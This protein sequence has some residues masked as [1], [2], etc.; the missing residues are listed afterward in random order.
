MSKVIVNYKIN[1]KINRLNAIYIND[2]IKFIEEKN[3][4]KYDFE[5]LLLKR[6]NN[7]YTLSID[8]KNN[9]CIYELKKINQNLKIPMIIKKIKHDKNYIDVIYEIDGQQFNFYLEIEEIK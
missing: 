8:F 3:I 2:N 7:E 9:N 5:K 6:E 4:I 1:D